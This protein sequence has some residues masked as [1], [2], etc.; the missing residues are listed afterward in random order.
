VVQNFA[1]ND[2]AFVQA[3]LKEAQ[4]EWVQANFKPENPTSPAEEALAQARDTL[5]QPPM[6]KAA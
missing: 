2:L 1:G 3:E 4:K 6:Q 5:K